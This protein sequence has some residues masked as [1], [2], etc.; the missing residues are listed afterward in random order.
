[1]YFRSEEFP[2]GVPSVLCST[3]FHVGKPENSKFCFRGVVG[4]KLRTFSK[5]IRTVR[6]VYDVAA[7]HHSHLGQDVVI[8]SEEINGKTMHVP[9]VLYFVLVNIKL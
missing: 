4:G 5:C 1:M 9:Y 8:L 2:F 6:F 7:I 3:A